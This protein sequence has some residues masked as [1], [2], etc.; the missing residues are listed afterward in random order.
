MYFYCIFP[1]LFI[2]PIPLQSHTSLFLFTCCYSSHSVTWSVTN[3]LGIL[4]TILL[5]SMSHSLLAFIS[6]SSF[7]E[8]SYIPFD[9]RFFLCFFILDSFCLFLWF[10]S[11]ALIVVFMRWTSLVEVLWD[12]VVWFLW[13]PCLDALRL[14]FILFVCA[15]LL[16][17]CFTYWLLLYWWVLPSSGLTESH[18]FHFFLYAIVQVLVNKAVLPDNQTYTSKKNPPTTSAIST[19]IELRLIMMKRDCGNYKIYQQEYTMIKCREN[20]IA[21]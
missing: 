14:P 11:C 8:D 13:F 17:L 4:V 1:T 20:I 21:W 2:S 15:L 10:W 16:Y 12:S 19:S 5:N 3:S 7:T 6:F 18:N 9:Y